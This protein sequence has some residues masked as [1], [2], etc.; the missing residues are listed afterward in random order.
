MTELS[1]EPGA[2]AWVEVDLDAL[3]ANFQVI[4][5]T[6]SPTRGVLPMVKAEAYGLGAERVVRALEPLEPWGYGVATVEEGATLRA[7]G[8]PRPIL[9]VAPMPPGAEPRAA[10]AG[11]TPSLSTVAAVE[12]WAA[13][14]RAAGRRLD[15]HVEV[16]TGMG[17]AGFDWRDADEWGRAVAQ[18][19]GDDVAWTGVFTHFHSADE[20]RLELRE[21][22][23]AE[24]GGTTL[25]Q[26]ER[27][28]QAVAGLPVARDRLLV[29]AANSAGAL[30]WPELALDLV[31]PGIFLY[32]GTV[33]GAPEPAQVAQVR[34][35]VALVRDVPPGATTGYGA[36]YSA[37]VR[38]RWATLGIGY[39]DGLPRALGNRGVA[40][41]RG[42]RVPIRG[43][44]SMD[45][46]V[47]DVTR[48]P[49]VEEGDVA[50]L[51][52]SDGD[53]RI[54]LD[55]VAERAN[56]ISYEILTGLGRRLERIQASG[57]GGTT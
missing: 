39:G 14:A 1:I 35:R 32:G 34:A 9:V 18:R 15:F 23:G 47:V 56:T 38:S 6:A 53:A 16:D 21:G 54:P 40:L 30:G 28:R 22:A 24:I 19:A 25:E 44:I 17:R 33:P 7:A 48:V 45:M 5:A 26:A 43:R 8:V 50:T 2:R 57:A 52:G 12:R 51:V 36:T 4:R 13:A 41:V 10:E 20:E 46:I 31:R 42:R 55:E 37:P 3:R 29:H 11:L 27:L 49:D